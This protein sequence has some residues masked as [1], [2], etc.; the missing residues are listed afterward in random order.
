MTELHEMALRLLRTQWFCRGPSDI[1]PQSL[2]Q[3]RTH[4]SLTWARLDGR[5]YRAPMLSPKVY[6]S[7][8]QD[9]R[10]GG[11]TR[12]MPSDCRLIVTLIGESASRTMQAMKTTWHF[13]STSFV[14]ADSG[15]AS[16]LIWQTQL[17]GTAT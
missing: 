16:G 7:G 14:A 11:R 12:L 17:Q 1:S 3:V 6:G 2:A 5:G 13:V 15:R 9:R 4:L 10:V 8:M